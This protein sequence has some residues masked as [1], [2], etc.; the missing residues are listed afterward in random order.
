[1][2]TIGGELDQLAALR[3][4][5]DRQSQVIQELTSAV[6]ADVDNTWWMG[7]AADRF[8]HAWSGEFE[9]TLRR[10]H[11]ALQDAGAEVSRRREALLRAGS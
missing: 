7:P 11:S 1:M 10:L 2:G 3:A 6:R 4:N 9:P 8:R 5:L